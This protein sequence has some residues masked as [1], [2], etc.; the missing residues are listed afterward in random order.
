MAG[1]MAMSRPTVAR[2]KRQV[3]DRLEVELGELRPGLRRA[4]MDQ[5]GEIL[6][7]EGES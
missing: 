1:L 4:V 5:L 3:F 2:I 6:N 7:R